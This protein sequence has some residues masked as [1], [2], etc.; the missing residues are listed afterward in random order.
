ML[1]RIARHL[2]SIGALLAT[3]LTVGVVVGL[4]AVAIFALFATAVVRGATQPLDEA[5]LRALNGLRG[6]T[7]DRIAVEVTALGNGAVL[8][9]LVAVASV[10]LWLTRHRWSASLLVAA[11]IGGE[12]LNR[13]LKEWFARPRPTIVEHLYPTSSPSF[14]SGHAM[15][16][17]I[18]YGAIAYLVGRLEPTAALRRTTWSVAAV[19]IL[20]IGAS[21]SY[22]GVHYPSDVLAGYLAGLAWLAFIAA[23]LGALRMLARERPETHAEEHDLNAEAQ[24]AAQE[25]A[26]QART[27]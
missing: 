20:A 21:R 15:N 22:L 18:T 26:Q 1:R 23:A 4:G 11:F 14:P 25:E 19:L 10:F 3:L 9:L 17:F 5:V 13:V 27:G 7:L 24:H 12:V 8:L 2:K 16:A 6:G